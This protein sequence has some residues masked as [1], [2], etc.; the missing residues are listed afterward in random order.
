MK[1]HSSL[2]NWLFCL[3]ERILYEHSPWYRRKL[4][5]CSWLCSSPVLPSSV[6]VSLDFPCTAHAIL[7]ERLSN[8]SQGLHC[9]FPG[10]AQNLILFLCWIHHEITSGQ[11]HDSR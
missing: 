4:C 6:S 1:R 9:T 2:R 3:S 10:F 5:V 7:P 8:H 11:I